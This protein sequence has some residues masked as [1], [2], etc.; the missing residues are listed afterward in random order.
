MF[1]FSPLPP[2]NRLEYPIIMEK[3]WGKELSF[4]FNKTMFLFFWLVNIKLIQKTLYRSSK[5]PNRLADMHCRPGSCSSYTEI[6]VYII[7]STVLQDNLFN[8]FCLEGVSEEAN[9]I[10]LDFSPSK[11][12]KVGCFMQKYIHNFLLLYHLLPDPVLIKLIIKCYV[13]GDRTKTVCLTLECLPALSKP[14]R[15]ELS[16]SCIYI[17]GRHKIWKYI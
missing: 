1:Q 3:C 9:E 6:V 4:R 5:C 13:N 7:L 15:F 11:L 2:F 12:Y 17:S 10:Y 8:E 16:C 14:C